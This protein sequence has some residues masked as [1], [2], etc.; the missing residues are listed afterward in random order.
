MTLRRKL[1]IGEVIKM[2]AKQ[3]IITT[4]E[5]IQYDETIGYGRN[6]SGVYFRGEAFEPVPDPKEIARAYFENGIHVPPEFAEVRN[7]L[8]GLIA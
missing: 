5:D 2:I 4:Y 8:A 7:I 1:S 6:A 3:R